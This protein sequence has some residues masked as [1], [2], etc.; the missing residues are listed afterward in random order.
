MNTPVIGSDFLFSITD[1]LK[2]LFKGVIGLAIDYALKTAQRFCSLP[3][4]NFL[5]FGHHLPI[6]GKDHS[7]AIHGSYLLFNNTGWE[8][9]KRIQRLQF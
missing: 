2:L 6:F 3:K 4:E 1:A 9:S 7:E 8:T 5:D